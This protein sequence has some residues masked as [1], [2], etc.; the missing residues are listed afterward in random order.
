MR[1][2]KKKNQN[3]LNILCILF[4][5][6]RSL[7]LADACWALSYLSDGTNDKIEEVVNAGVVHRLVEL[8]GSDNLNAVTP[9]LRAIGNVVTG[10]DQQVWAL[11]TTYN[12]FFSP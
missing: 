6:L 4:W 10:S 12:T 1:K 3:H 8:L 11:I 9:C 7:F 5:F 2:K